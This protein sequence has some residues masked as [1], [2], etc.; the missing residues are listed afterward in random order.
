M[1]RVRRRQREAIAG[2]A[3][4]GR[5]TCARSRLTSHVTLNENIHKPIVGHLLMRALKRALLNHPAAPVSDGWRRFF[6][7]DDGQ[8]SSETHRLRDDEENSSMPSCSVFNS[9]FSFIQQSLETSDLLDVSTKKSVSTQSER[10]RLKSE[11]LSSGALE[12][13]TAHS[14]SE[15]STVPIS[16]SEH[17]AF[18]LSNSPCSIGQ[19]KSLLLDRELWLADLDVQVSSSMTSNASRT[20]TRALW[21]LKSRLRL[22]WLV[23]LGLLGHVGLR[24]HDSVLRSESRR[25][26][27]E[28]R[29][30][31]A[32]LSAEQSHEHQGQY[33]TMMFRIARNTSYWMFYSVCLVLLLCKKWFYTGL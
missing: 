27:K 9:S 32:R 16:Q 24:Q 19:Q 15:I 28:V 20:L 8:D 14:Q 33:D 13:H 10:D 7:R 11:T 25:C 17:E 30:C 23:R 22:D 18:S 21:T 31:S 26:D 29:G 6:N 3:S 5:D 4:D 1:V 2:G 12:P